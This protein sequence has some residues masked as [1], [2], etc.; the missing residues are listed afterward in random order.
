MVV[1]T[2]KLENRRGKPYT[3]LSPSGNNYCS[4]LVC[5]ILHYYLSIYRSVDL[6]YNSNAQFY[7]LNYFHMKVFWDLMS[8]CCHHALPHE[9]LVF[10]L[11]IT[12][13]T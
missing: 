10:K 8:V 4:P 3:C 1:Y 11:N 9:I 7:K 12:F 13:F 6:L 5:L 2:D